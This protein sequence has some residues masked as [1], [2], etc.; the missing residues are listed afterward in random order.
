MRIE[1]ANDDGVVFVFDEPLK[2]SRSSFIVH[3]TKLTVVSEFEK[4]V[5]HITFK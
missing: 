1:F 4:M 3:L 5:H 2:K